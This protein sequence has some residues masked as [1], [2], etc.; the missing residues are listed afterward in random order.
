M[1]PI[2]TIDPGANGGICLKTSIDLRCFKIPAS[3]AEK[4]ALMID[5]Q[6]QTSGKLEAIMEDVGFHV[7]GNR[8][9]GSAKLARHVGQLEGILMALDIP[10][11]YVRPQTWMTAFPDR[12]K[13]TTKDERAALKRGFPS[14][15]V[16]QFKQVIDKENAHRKRLRKVFIKAKVQK[17]YPG[18]K[19]YARPNGKPSNKVTDWAADALGI[20]M[21][22]ESQ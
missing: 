14:Y 6:L 15:S 2:L 13:A 5:L 19:I 10:V 8:A 20:L 22:A 3:L 4:A 21:W 12:P 7:E 1:Q 11:R 17:A 18:A 9:Q 16:S